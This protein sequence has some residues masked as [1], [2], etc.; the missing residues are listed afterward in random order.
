MLKAYIVIGP[1]DVTP[2]QITASF[3][4]VKQQQMCQ[5]SQLFCHSKERLPSKNCHPGLSE[6]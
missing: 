3:T 2:G 4:G 5:K 6:L 1:K